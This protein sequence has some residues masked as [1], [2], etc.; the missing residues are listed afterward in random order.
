MSTCKH[1]V[2]QGRAGGS[3]SWCTTCG[4]KVYE[5]EIRKCQACSHY[6]KNLAGS[7]CMKHLMGVT[8]DM[9]VTFEI[10]KGSCFEPK[11]QALE[12]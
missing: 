10:S 4:E 11:A 7:A 8:A 9:H 12:A 1:T 6:R 2:T 3:G 5:V